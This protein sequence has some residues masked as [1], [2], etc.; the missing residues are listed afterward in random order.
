MGRALPRHRGVWLH[1]ER[2][3]WEFTRAVERDKGT[4]RAWARRHQEL[5]LAEWCRPAAGSAALATAWYLWHDGG[6][7]KKTNRGSPGEAWLQF[8][9]KLSAL[10]DRITE[11][12]GKT[13]YWLVLL[14]VIVS[15]GN[16]SIRYAFDTSSN[17]WLELQWYLFSAIFLLCAGYALLRNQHVRIDII[18]GRLPRKVQLW[19]DILG[20]IF[21]LFPMAIIIMWLSWPYFIESVVR[22]EVSSNA[23]GLI[24]WPVKLLIPVGFFLLIVQNV[25]EIIKRVARLQGLIPDF[26]ERAHGANPEE[27]AGI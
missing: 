4:G 18:N 16:A 23:G 1:P 26:V 13:V 6:Q 19:I 21:F 2:A 25:S 3:C 8:L 24:R 20:G 11:S 14:S 7:N 5:P 22:H 15:A 9:L 27:E 10:I 17:A 12:I